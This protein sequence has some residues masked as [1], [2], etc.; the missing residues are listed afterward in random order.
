MMPEVPKGAVNASDQS[1]MSD[2][3]ESKQGFV[4]LPQPT[5]R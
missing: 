2:V 3:L 1:D 5:V 4:R